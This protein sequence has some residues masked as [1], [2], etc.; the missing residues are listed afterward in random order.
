MEN[1][2]LMGTASP[3]GVIKI[4]WKYIEVMLHNIEKI[5]NYYWIELSN[6]QFM[7]WKFHLNNRSHQWNV[8]KKF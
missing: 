5:L 8:D 3:L 2:S 4:F 7:L 6:G 1:N